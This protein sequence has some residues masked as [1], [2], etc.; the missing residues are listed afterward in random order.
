MNVS[1]IVSVIIT[2]YNRPDLLPRAINS[3]LNQTFDNLECI[4]VD[5]CSPDSETKTLVQSADDERLRYIR[6]DKNRGVSAARNTGIERSRGEYIA[7]LD[8]D[9]EWLPTK[10]QKQISVFDDLSDSYA[11]VYC[12]MDY[13]SDNQD[14][15]IEKYRPKLEGNIFPKTLD[16]Q[17]IGSTSTLVVRKDI[18]E[19]FDGFDE[20]LPRGVDGD[21]IRR[22][23]QE[24][25]FDYVPEALVRYYIEHGHK[26]ITRDDAEGI[27]NRI[28]GLQTKLTKF[29]AALD[30]YPA[31]AANIYGDLAFQYG[32]LGEWSHSVRYYWKAI[33]TAPFSRYPYFWILRIATVPLPQVIQKPIKYIYNKSHS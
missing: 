1:P 7:F 29:D 25:K 9:D 19:E 2:T 12:W 6:H 5:D 27:R 31:R 24:Y 21:F 22:V 4:V 15:I 16:G 14:E 23:S 20:S 11:I 13:Y 33:L 32:R 18:A 26:R 30:S 28:N 8:D 10:I 17:P 3:V